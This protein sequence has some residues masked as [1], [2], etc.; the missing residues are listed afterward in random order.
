[1]FQE[2]QNITYASHVNAFTY[3]QLIQ[4]QFIWSVEKIMKYN[5]P[6]PQKKMRQ[7]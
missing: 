1:M 4:K 6:P 5:N 7:F 2:R 3:M